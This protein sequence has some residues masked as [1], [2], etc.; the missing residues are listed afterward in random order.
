M[1]GQLDDHRIKIDQTQS[2]QPLQFAPHRT[3]SGTHET[4]QD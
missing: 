2:A 3:F 4:D 1:P